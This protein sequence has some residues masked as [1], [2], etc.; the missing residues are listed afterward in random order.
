MEIV[1][2]IHVRLWKAIFWTVLCPVHILCRVVQCDWC[3]N[4]YLSCTDEI[5]S[6]IL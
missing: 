4:C 2:M 6:G 3:T 1:N 5:F